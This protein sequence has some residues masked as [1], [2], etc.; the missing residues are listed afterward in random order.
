MSLFTLFLGMLGDAVGN[1][2]NNDP[3]DVRT[4]KSNLQ[5]AGYFSADD[6]ESTDN[7]F[8]T[9]K[10]DEGI[11]KFQKDNNLKIDGI[12]KPSGETERTLYERLTGQYA[13]EVFQVAQ[14][15]AGTVGFGGN[16]SGTFAPV[17]KKKPV[18]P[19]RFNP[20]FDL[21][22]APVVNKGDDRVQSIL[23]NTPAKFE[24]KFK[25]QKETSEKR[26]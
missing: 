17:P 19:E 8:L 15:D 9:R 12:M 26:R 24:I 2:Q 20:S 13:G 25:K 14:N 11:K 22:K 7:P 18:K 4:T 5:K 16:I 23:N 3:A 21:E 6:K 1:N 10:M